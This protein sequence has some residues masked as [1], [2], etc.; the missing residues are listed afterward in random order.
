M[1]SVE[2]V[3]RGDNTPLTW[4]LV[5]LVGLCDRDVMNTLAAWVV[6]DDSDVS[7]F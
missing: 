7:D 1:N 5:V 2:F 3:E 6:G 4:G